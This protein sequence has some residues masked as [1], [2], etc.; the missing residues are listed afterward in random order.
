MSVSS[1]IELK[2]ESG[3][4]ARSRSKSVGLGKSDLIKLNSEEKVRELSVARMASF[5][6][7][8]R[9]PSSQARST[10]SAG[11]RVPQL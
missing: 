2:A 1:G 9:S 6:D 4:P 10:I 5:A 11:Y 3:L 7:L 8:G